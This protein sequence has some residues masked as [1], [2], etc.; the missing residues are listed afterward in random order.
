MP[1]CR[2]ADRERARGLSRGLSAAWK[3]S[4]SGEN[5]GEQRSD[6]ATFDRSHARSADSI[7]Y[8]AVSDA[9]SRCSRSSEKLESRALWCRSHAA[10]G[11]QG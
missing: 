9:D 4:P 11:K 8:V 6:N 10:S 1:T 2:R 3:K 7:D 5:I